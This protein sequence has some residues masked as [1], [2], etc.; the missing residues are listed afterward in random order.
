M[1]VFLYMSAQQIVQKYQQGA[2]TGNNP[3]TNEFVS[4]IKQWVA[5]DDAIKDANDKLKQYRLKKKELGTSIQGYMKK[6]NIE[7]HDI[8]ITGAGKVRYR[9]TTRMVP[10]NKEYIYKRLID[11][12]GGN[13]KKALEAVTFIFSN[14]E[15]VTS[16]TLSRTRPRKPKTK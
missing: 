14:R 7:N 3:V 12:F 6:N 8:N 9:T 13:E 16:A 1:C 2:M 10:I 15:R 4:A 11:F 5:Y